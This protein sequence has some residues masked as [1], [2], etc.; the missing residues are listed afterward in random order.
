MGRR[1]IKDT[2]GQLR[3]EL[4]LSQQELS[5]KFKEVCGKTISREKIKNWENGEREIKTED[6]ILLSD[7]FGVSADYLLGLSEYRTIEGS[8]KEAAEYTGLAEIAINALR[9]IKEY[10]DNNSDDSQITFC[11]LVSLLLAAPSFM[12]LLWQLL[13]VYNSRKQLAESIGRFNLGEEHR[14][15]LIMIADIVRHDIQD[16]LEEFRM[17]LEDDMFQI[18]EVLGQIRNAQRQWIYNSH[19]VGD[20]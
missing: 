2:I 10:D 6:I 17:L 20:K 18:G 13:D 4:G 9:S 7:F 11:S 16:S 5:D 12:N 14:D 1:K 3:D 15:D 19:E 8:M